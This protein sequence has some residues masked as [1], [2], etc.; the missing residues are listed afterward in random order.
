MDLEGLGDLVI[1]EL[2]EKTE[3]HHLSLVGC[4]KFKALPYAVRD[5]LRLALDLRVDD[6]LIERSA[7]ITR[8]EMAG[9]EITAAVS[10]LDVGPQVPEHR[11]EVVAERRFFLP[12]AKP[13]PV[14]RPKMLESFIDEAVPFGRWQL[15]GDLPR[16]C[17]RLAHHPVA[18]PPILGEDAGD[19]CGVLGDFG[20]HLTA[21]SIARFQVSEGG[22]QY[23]PAHPIKQRVPSS[24]TTVSAVTKSMFRR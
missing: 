20:V 22:N 1:G 6:Q 12:H 2:I 23:F 16:Q 19:Q 11:L 7:V 8:P 3:L 21:E 15:P 14:V 24:T 13:P 5:L 4:D 17:F 10:P 18:G 9:K